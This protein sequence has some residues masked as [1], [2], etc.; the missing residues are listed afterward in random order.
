M[1]SGASIG[2]ARLV[3]VGNPAAVWDGATE[4]VC[5]LFCSNLEGDLWV[6][7]RVRVRVGFGRRLSLRRLT[8]PN[9]NPNQVWLLFCSNLKEDQEWQIHARQGR[10]SEGRRVWLSSSA[11]LGKSW[12]PPREITAQVKRPGWTWY[13]TGPGAGVQLE[14][15]RLLLPCNHAEDVEEREHPYLVS[16][17]RSRMVAHCVS[18]PT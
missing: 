5:L 9:P 13:A 18:T 8:H 16:W 11:D 4:T 6:R 17:G 1:C 2:K 10:D 7:V 3:T 15:G 14:S 12:S